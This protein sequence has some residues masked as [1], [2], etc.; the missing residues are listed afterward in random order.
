MTKCQNLN[1][2]YIFFLFLIHL[3]YEIISPNQKPFKIYFHNSLSNTSKP[4]YENIADNS[5]ISTQE[6]FNYYYKH[7]IISKI[8]IGNP[9]HCFNIEISFSSPR[10]WIC[11]APE[12]AF[13]KKQKKYV[14]SK[15][16]TF[17][18]LNDPEKIMTS[19]GI[20]TGNYSRDLI[21]VGNNSIHNE[22]F[23]F[24]L[25]E[26]CDNF[27]LGEIGIGIDNYFSCNF[28]QLSIIQQLKEKKI[29]SSSIISMRYIN[30]T[31]G[32]ILLGVN[33]DNRKKKFIEYDIPSIDSSIVISSFIESMYIL[34]QI[35][36][37]NDNSEE[38]TVFEKRIPIQLFN[39][40]RFEIDFSSS[41]ISVP[42]EVFDNLIDMEFGKYI[43]NKKLCEIKVDINPNIKYFICDNKILNTNLDKL[44]IVINPETSLKI[45]IDELFLPLNNKK[46][47]LFGIISE[48]NINYVY[49]GQIFL[50]NYV[51]YFNSD[52]KFMRFYNKDILKVVNAEKYSL[53]LIVIIGICLAVI[54]YYMLSITCEKKNVQMI[55]NS[56]VEKFL[57]KNYIT[58][59]HNKKLKRYKR[60]LQ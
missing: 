45:N 15:S 39:K 41:L 5:S 44:I 31:Y 10:T 37:V 38:E 58:K 23:D 28:S 40:L 47:I 17:K 19:Q 13:Q 56:N 4:I 29:I 6:I 24:F 20:K 32:E 33:Y 46:K 55:S 51:I 30:N 49:I 42:E 14:S 27:E 53:I 34:K 7:N 36:D 35:T 43:N 8:C 12:D 52:K 48:K 3:Q 16:L 22:Y 57:R 59:K 60:F 50:K 54:M 18:Q 26:N 11:G 2:P 25:V 21:K 9:K 1:K